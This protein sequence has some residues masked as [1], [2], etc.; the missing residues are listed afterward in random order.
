MELVVFVAALLVLAI[1]A[2]IF[3]VDS[4]ELGAVDQRATERW[5]K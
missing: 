5:T 1:L 2:N 4:R 3:G